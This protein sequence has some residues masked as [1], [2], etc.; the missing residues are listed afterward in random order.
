MKK[1]HIGEWQVLICAVLWSTGG[2]FIK[3]I[4]WHPLVI[5]GA[6]SL[7]SAFM[8]FLFLRITNQKL[9]FNRQVILTAFFMSATFI[10]FVIANK[11]TTAANAIVLQFTSPIYIMLFS[12]LFLK[13]KFR[14]FDILTVV[15]T[16]GG[17]FLFMLD[18]IETGHTLGNIMALIAGIF[19]AGTYLSI[20][21]NRMELRMSGVFFGHILTALV[22][23]PFAF[24]Y[25]T[26]LTGQNLLFTALLGVVQLGI[27]YIL[28]AFAMERCSPLACSLIGAAEPLLNPVWVFLFDGEAPS[29]LSLIGGII[30]I[31]TITLWCVWKPKRKTA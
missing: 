28:L 11:L 9:F 27:P 21:E 30:V 3:M 26:P 14:L 23:L 18:G 5:A 12:A 6:R 19:F 15:L 7:I 1:N 13:A 10:C 29:P 22:G 31:I 8:V 24:L 25:E 2:I 20:G 16:L 17:I 4:E